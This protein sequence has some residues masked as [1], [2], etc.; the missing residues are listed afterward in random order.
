MCDYQELQN[1]FT[2]IKKHL[3]SQCIYENIDAV[4]ISS[5]SNLI[6]FF[7][8]DGRITNKISIFD[9]IFAFYSEVDQEIIIQMNDRK[10]TQKLKPGLYTIPI[11]NIIPLLSMK[12]S[13]FNIISEKNIDVIVG[14]C[15]SDM[16][17]NFI[18]NNKVCTKI[19]TD[20]E[21]DIMYKAG[22]IIFDSKTCNSDLYI[23]KLP[24][25]YIETEEYRKYIARRFTEQIKYELFEK[26]L[27]PG[28][29]KSFLSIDKL[30]KYNIS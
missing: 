9:F 10:F 7:K 27:A 30:K 21:E 13:T 14:K 12:L 6:H 19:F 5:T 22:N 26:T 25:Y 17:R 3:E 1:Y 29:M 11:C 18:V 23:I 2:N 16:I 20:K 28:R 4:P 24:Y 8:Y 15:A